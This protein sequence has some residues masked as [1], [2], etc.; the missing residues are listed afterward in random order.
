[1]GAGKT[2]RGV[3]VRADLRRLVRHIRKRW[4][5]THVTFRGDGHYARP[6]AIDWCEKNGFDYVFGLTGTKPLTKKVDEKAD[7][8][9]TQRALENSDVVRDYAETRHKAGSWNRERRAAARI[10]A[11]RLGLVSASSSPT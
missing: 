5:K 8:V 9:G 2:P 7:I 6:E 3:E 10:E 11:T 1:M 4:P